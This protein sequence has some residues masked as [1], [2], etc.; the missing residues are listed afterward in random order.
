MKGWVEVFAPA[1]S[2]AHRPH[3]WPTSGSLLLADAM[4]LQVGREAPALPDDRA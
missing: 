2:E 3:E 1:V 4:V